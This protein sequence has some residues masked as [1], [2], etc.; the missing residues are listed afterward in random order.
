MPSPLTKFTGHERDTESGLDYFGARY[1]A[2]L[3]GRF[4]S[5]DLPF[6]DQHPTNPQ[7]WNLY[8][9]ARNNPLKFTD[10]TGNSV[11]GASNYCANNFQNCQPME[12]GTDLAGQASP[13]QTI[14]VTGVSDAQIAKAIA[15]VATRLGVSQAAAFGIVFS[16]L[17]NLTNT[18][19]D[20]RNT[21]KRKAIA[22]TAEGY[23]G[24][25]AW[26]TS[27][28]KDDFSAGTNKCNKFVY[29]V[30]KEAR[31][32]AVVE[33]KDGTT[34]QPLASEWADPKLRIDNW[35]V[36]GPAEAPQPGDVAAYKIIPPSPGATGH[37]GIIVSD[38]K[39][40]VLSISAHFDKVGPPSTQFINDKRTVYRRYTGP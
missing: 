28:K 8:A 9:Y 12:G 22:Q 7:S 18:S 3:A 27:A 14:S 25:T 40:G 31:A 21:Q 20:V 13:T 10:P 19:Q 16:Y 29:D 39:G 2:S 38:G 36:L 33:L 5:P 4:Q 17:A 37:S 1:Y 34:R 35:R 6:I 26:A 32:E 24:S 23:D 15:T 30:T 11:S